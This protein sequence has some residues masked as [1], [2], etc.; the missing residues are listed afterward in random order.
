MLGAPLIVA[1]SNSFVV[2]NKPAGIVVHEGDGCLLDHLSAAGHPRG[3]LHP[4]HRLDVGTSGIVLVAKSS[5]SAARL[6]S[7]LASTASTKAYLGVCRGTMPLAESGAWGQPLSRRAEGRNNPAGR[8]PERRPA[9]TAYRVL[10][11]AEH[12]SLLRIELRDGGR[13]HQIRRHAALAGHAIAGD[14][15]YGDR[16]HAVHMERQ[17]GLTSAALHAWRLCVPVGNDG[18]GELRCFEAPP[19][20][21]WRKLPFGIADDVTLA[22][23]HGQRIYETSLE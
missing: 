13:T 7:A 14:T 3:K 20:E 19:P 18:E 10:A 15:R 9:A 12:L 4:V 11:T 1:E 5:A 6:Q 23:A 16:R 8:R 22:W 2:A 17:Y 21:G